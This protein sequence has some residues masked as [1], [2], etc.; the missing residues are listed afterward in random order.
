MC[1]RPTKDFKF[2]YFALLGSLRKT[3]AGTTR[4]SEICVFNEKKTMISA[5][6]ARLARAFFHFDKFV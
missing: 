1:W 4:M 2:G 6:A 3:T 5:R